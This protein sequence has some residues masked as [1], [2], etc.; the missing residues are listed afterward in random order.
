MGDLG[1]PRGWLP[2]RSDYKAESL[3]PAT[4]E[5]GARSRARALNRMCNTGHAVRGLSLKGRR[6]PAMGRCLQ[7]LQCSRTPCERGIS[8]TGKRR[9]FIKHWQCFILSIFVV[10]LQGFTI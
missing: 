5:P 3:G 4:P 2:V 8:V 10:S 1:A 7:H 9:S 6:A